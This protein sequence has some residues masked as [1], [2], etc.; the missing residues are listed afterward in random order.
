M[1]HLEAPSFSGSF[2]VLKNHAP[3]LAV[4]KKGKVKYRYN[5][6]TGEFDV[7]EGFI[8]VLPDKVRILVEGCAE[9]QSQKKK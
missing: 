6:N 3:L 4:L 9:C 8:E 7:K 2:G 5:E 1:E